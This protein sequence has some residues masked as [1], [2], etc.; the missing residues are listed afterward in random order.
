VDTE[1]SEKIIAG[2]SESQIRAVARQKGYESLLYDGVQKV[3][4]GL[5]TAE[6]V[7][8]VAATDKD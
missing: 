8:G 1:L 2:Q 5:T 6:E 7:I 3:L 4:Q